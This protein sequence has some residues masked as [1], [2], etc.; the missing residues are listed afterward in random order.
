[1]AQT[2]EKYFPGLSEEQKAQFDKL[3]TELTDWNSKIN[4]ISRKDIENLE[5]NH[6][7]HSLA[8]AKFVK[9]KPGTRILDFGTGGGIPGL[10]LAI[11][12]PD[13]H[14]HLIDRIGKK[15]KVAEEVAKAVG[16]KNVSF[17]KGDIGECHEKFD[18]VVTRGVMDLAPMLKLLARN[19]DQKHQ[20]NAIPNG[21][22]ALKGGE[23]GS[24]IS[25]VKAPVELTDLSGWF[26]EPFFQTKKLVY[27]S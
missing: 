4:V 1:M 20:I 22:L 15:V 19:I 17:Q 7:L 18:F 23:L 21:V 14:F 5:I 2:I 25:A 10:P 12:F 8:I 6:I 11:M 9:F 13:V 24:E 27:V 16:L 26:E 3:M